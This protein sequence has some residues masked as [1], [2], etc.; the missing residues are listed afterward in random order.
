MNKGSNPAPDGGVRFTRFE[1]LPPDLAAHVRRLM[2][3]PGELRKAERAQA[4]E[5][6]PVRYAFAERPLPRGAIAAVLRDPEG[7][8]RRALILSES[9]ISPR[10]TSLARLALYRDE[11]EFPEATARR[12]LF[13]WADQRVEAEGKSWNL[14]AVLNGGPPGLVNDLLAAPRG[15]SIDVPELGPVRV[16]QTEP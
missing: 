14:N 12:V 4:L 15:K 8:P 9:T 16:V 7:E 6:V 10:A 5:R 13:I 3:D 1:D 2:N 11:G